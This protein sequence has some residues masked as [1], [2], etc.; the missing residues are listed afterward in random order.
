MNPIRNNNN[1]H[2]EN[3][4]KFTVQANA[5]ISNGVKLDIGC[6]NL[7]KEGYTGVDILKLPGVDI[8]CD[9]QKGLP[10]VVSNSVDEIHCSMILEHINDLTTVMREFHRVL[11]PS[12]ELIIIVP[13]CF[14]EMAFR[15]PTHCRYFTCRTFKYFDK[16]HSHSYYHDFH[17]KFISSR[18]KISREKPSLFDRFLEWFI[19]TNQPR[20]ERLLKIIP[21][22]NWIVHSILK[23]E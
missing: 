14:S 5:D 20:G 8:A 13:H 17:F 12:G 22:R 2:K 15:D 7:K 21:Y 4:E 6:G 11:K 19:N 9:I 3:T 10:M 1:G 18:I 23:K 16:S